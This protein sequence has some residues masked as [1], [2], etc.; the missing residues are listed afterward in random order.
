VPHVVKVI[1]M[2]V[3]AVIVGVTIMDKKEKHYLGSL[4]DH[5]VRKSTSEM[6][7]KL[8]AAGKKLKERF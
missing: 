7:E 1:M 3:R 5:T 2:N 4:D 6:D 8:N